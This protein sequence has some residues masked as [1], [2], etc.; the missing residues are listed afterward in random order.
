MILCP[1]VDELVPCLQSANPPAKCPTCCAS[2]LPANVP[3]LLHAHAGHHEHP[4][5]QI[6]V[7][8]I[9]P[10]DW[11]STATV[12]LL[13]SSPAVSTMCSNRTHYCEAT[14]ELVRQGIFTIS[15]RNDP[16]KTNWAKAWPIMR[17]LYD[18]PDA[19][20]LVEKQPCNLG[21]VATLRAYL[22]RLGLDYR[23]IVLRR[24]PCLMKPFLH[25]T[26]ETDAA[27]VKRVL[28]E[29]PPKRVLVLDFEELATRPDTVA[30]RLLDFLPQLASLRL[31]ETRVPVEGK[32][33]HN[34]GRD[35]PA[36]AYTRSAFC[37]V[38]MQAKFVN[39][40]H[41]RWLGF[42]VSESTPVTPTG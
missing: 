41:M 37:S 17:S 23:F 27:H 16:S 40:S 10:P 8:V 35:L 29:T 19:P 32:R 42:D 1:T 11:G 9:S 34:S 25:R 6:Q 3:A 18:R 22:E 26:L 33:E 31:D 14:H 2:C 13:S 38:R 21:K 28:L 36:L 20:V 39:A 5:H 30:R 4:Q 24:Q 12:G 7:H 15:E